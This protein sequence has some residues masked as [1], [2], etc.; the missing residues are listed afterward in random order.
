[1]DKRIFVSQLRHRWE[2]DERWR[3]ITRPYSPDDVWRLAGTVRID[4]SL[5]RLGA[6]RLWH[7]STPMHTSER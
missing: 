7:P 6:E 2:R 4:H 1:M 3:G 5:A